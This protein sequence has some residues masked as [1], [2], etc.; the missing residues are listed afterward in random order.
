M[1]FHDGK[2]EIV[3]MKNAIGEFPEGFLWGAATA[4]YQ[5]EGAVTEG[6]RGKN[7]WDTF[8]H[9]PGAIKNGENGDIAC[10]HYHRWREDIALMQQLN[11]DAYRFSIAWSRIF[12]QGRGTVNLAGLDFY[13]RLIDG[14]LE[15]GIQPFVTLYHWDLPQALQDEGKGWLRRGIVEDFVRYTDVVTRA[16][17]DR[18]KHWTTFNEPGVFTWGGY[19]LG[20]DAPG[21][22]MQPGA[23]LTALHHVFLAHGASAQVIRENVPQSQVGIVLDINVAEPASEA[24]E[25][26]AAAL[27]FD[28]M[29]NRWF[30]DAL[31][32][33][34]YPADMVA[35]FGEQMPR[36]ETGD[37][38]RMAVPLD[39][40]GINIYRRSVIAHGDELVPVNYCRVL[41]PGEHT[42]MGWEVYPKCIY[43]IL[44]YVNERYSPPKIYI[45]ENGI[46]L[47]DEVSPD[48]HVHDE[49]RIAYLRDHLTYL[50]RAIAEG[51]P[52]RG[53]FVWTLMDNFEWALGF[54][55][56]FGLIYVDHQ[57]QQRI[58]KDSGYFYADIAK[59]ET[60]V[61]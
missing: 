4:A 23:A 9:T 16:L 33:G 48:G 60:G 19:V 8:T 1:N 2:E 5:I 53:Y 35:L 14:L 32:R 41:P 50:Q 12:P 15:A 52:V 61:K 20:E 37:M 57:T 6:G 21:W 24:P 3:S 54:E 38:Q 29:Q 7:I 44:K 39:Y 43:D 11:L 46:A 51:V 47:P 45:T 22:R 34:E 58:M 56:R 27:R 10:D 59:K 18:V 17:G 28:G 40:L 55:P 30:L 26:V 36:I 13:S 31:L 49:R 42:L 25:D